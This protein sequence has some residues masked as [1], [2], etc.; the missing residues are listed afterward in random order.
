M[1]RPTRL[2]PP[3]PVIILSRM[4]SHCGACHAFP[5][6]RSGRWAP[7][8]TVSNLTIDFGESLILTQEFLANRLYNQAHANPTTHDMPIMS[9]RVTREAAEG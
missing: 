3:R 5:L 8:G 2:R 9:T 7:N 4:T 1:A 6:V